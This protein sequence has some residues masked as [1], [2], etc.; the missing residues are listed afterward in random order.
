MTSSTRARQ[1]RRPPNSP[2]TSSRSGLPRS[3]QWS[4]VRQAHEARGSRQSPAASAGPIRNPQHS[5]RLSPANP[6]ATH[7]TPQHRK[8]E[9][10]RV[11]AKGP[12]KRRS[13]TIAYLWKL[14]SM[15]AKG[16]S[17]SCKACALDILATLRKCGLGRIPTS[18]ARTKSSANTVKLS[19]DRW[20][21]AVP[22]DNATDKRH[23]TAATQP[24]RATIASHPKRL[25][26]C[27]GRLVRSKCHPPR[28]TVTRRRAA[29]CGQCSVLG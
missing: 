27:P 14:R 2:V 3:G 20:N 29:R 13:M 9:E 24:A 8:E 23:I 7:L 25:H 10:M 5:W 4:P 16:V 21:I 28:T 18:S 15:S 11:L 26:A 1:R 19:Q 12:S 17:P 22:F 6:V